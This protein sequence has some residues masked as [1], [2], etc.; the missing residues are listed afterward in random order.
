MLNVSIIAYEFQN[1]PNK[2]FYDINSSKIGI[3]F[4]NLYIAYLL[5]SKDNNIGKICN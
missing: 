3:L 5:K 1:L 2:Y 4:N